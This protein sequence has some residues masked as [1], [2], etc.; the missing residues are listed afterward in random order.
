[1]VQAHDSEE[2]HADEKEIIAETYHSVAIRLIFLASL[3]AVVLVGMSILYEKQ[4]HRYKTALFLGITIPVIIASVFLA[5]S[6][7]YVNVISESKGPVHWHTDFE[8]WNCGEWI[9]MQDPEGMSN[10]VGT[11]LFHEHG[12][13]RIHI[14]GVVLE[15]SHVGLED[16]FHVIG[17]HLHEGSLGIP[18]NNGYSTVNDGDLC[19]GK[20]GKLQVFVY[21]ITNPESRKGT[22]TFTQ[23]KITDVLSYKPAPYSTIPPGDCVIIEFGQEKDKTDKICGSYK[24]ALEKGDLRGS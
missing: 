6:T 23:E 21:K 24:H 12:D 20:P 13:N 2:D 7:I 9:E 17:G 5:W 15:E 4:V 16:F 3:I 8:I 11:S 22:W 14:E 10:R 1:M 18:T 19:N